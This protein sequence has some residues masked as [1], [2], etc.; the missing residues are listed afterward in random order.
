MDSKG[1]ILYFTNAVGNCDGFF[2]FIDHKKKNIIKIS[3]VTL[4]AK[5]RIKESKIL[6]RQQT[7]YITWN[8]HAFMKIQICTPSTKKIL[9]K[10]IPPAREQNSLW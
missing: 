7:P 10:G 1:C 5:E 3:A 2:R 4:F 9:R 6:L 8:I